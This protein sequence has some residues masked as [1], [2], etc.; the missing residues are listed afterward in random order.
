MDASP[1]LLPALGIGLFIIAMA[2]MM[3]GI[4]RAATKGMAAN[5]FV[6]IRLPSLMRDEAAWRAGHE[7]A[8]PAFF[9]SALVTTVPAALS[10]LVSDDETLYAGLLVVSTVALTLGSSL[11]C[12]AARRAARRAPLDG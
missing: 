3:W 7:A 1:H 9:W 5:P 8:V 10:V 2:W 12:L 6:G 4:T 11:A